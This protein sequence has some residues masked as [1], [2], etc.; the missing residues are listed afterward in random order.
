MRRPGSNHITESFVEANETGGLVRPSRSAKTKREAPFSLRLSI[1]EK[2]HL[3]SAAGNLPLAT[4]IKARMF[5]DLPAVPRQHTPRRCD[6]AL[7]GKVLAALGASRL[8][9]NLNQIAHVANLGTMPMDD[10]LTTALQTACADIRLIRNTLM[11]ALGH[12]KYKA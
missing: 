12:R 1:E 2:N 6:K 8:S 3:K 10:E 4:Y 11:K 7:L 9:S 5:E